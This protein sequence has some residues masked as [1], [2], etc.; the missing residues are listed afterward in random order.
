MNRTGLRRAYL[1]VTL[2]AVGIACVCFVEGY[3]GVI[4]DSWGYHHL[5]RIL[6]T[7]GL[8]GWPTDVR[9]YGY[10]LFLAAITGFRDLPPEEVR[11][12]AFGAQLAAYLGTCYWVSRRLS[13]ILRSE[14][15]GIWAYA[16]GGLNPILLIHTTEMLSDLLSAVLI[17]LAV[18][19]SWKLPE[20]SRVSRWQPFLSFLC[21]G[22]AV[23]LRPANVVV[24]WALALVW[25]FRVIRWRERFLGSALAAL[26]GLIPP[27]VPQMIINYELVGTLNPLL[28]SDIYRQQ[29]LWGMAALKYGTVLI[30]EHSP[31]LVYVNPFYRGDPGPRTFLLHHPVDYLATLALHAFGMIDAD[32]PFTYITDF[33]PWYRWPLSL[34]NYGLLYLALLGCVVGVAR[35]LRQRRID[36]VGF[37]LSTTIAVGAAYLVLYLPVE[38]EV[39]FGLPLLMLMTPL[40]VVG[41]CWLVAPAGGRLGS[42]AFALLGALVVIV[43]CARLSI[44]FETK[45]TNPLSPSPANMFVLDPPHARG[46]SATAIPTPP[47]GTPPES[48]RNP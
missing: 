5:S 15:A 40:A 24:V 46:P 16:I 47:P 9:T 10:P 48:A 26:A 19:S 35:T 8:L 13:A 12:I 32:L 30:P 38:V 22:A 7:K 45:R 41:A 29:R 14:S 18:A 33:N 4:F 21:A 11:L 42:R 1:A 36:E 3:P 23:A 34:A 17:Q 31:F 28:V 20:P 6:R 25:A 27:L 39:R 44:W 37:V 43:S 2:L